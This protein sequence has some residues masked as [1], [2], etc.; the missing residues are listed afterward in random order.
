MLLD[1]GAEHVLA[2]EPSAAF[3]VLQRN[4]A[5]HGQRVTCVLARGDELAP[6]PPVDLV[7]A[8]GVLHH[9]PEPGPVAAAA[10]AALR[11]GGR[12]VVWLYGKEGNAVYLA[13]VT[14]LR[15]VTTRLAAAPTEILA[16]VLNV[17]FTGYMRLARRVPLPLRGYIT[18]VFG[19]FTP[20]RRVQVIYDQLKPAYARYYTRGEAE[21]LLRNAG[22]QDVHVHHRHGY[23]WTVIGTKPGA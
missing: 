19:H 14:P 16:R 2:L 7:F 9:I 12:V 20:E 23:S 1:A 22:F 18:H 15:W 4:L 8:I 6:E 17:C 13:L 10:Y 21:V 11:P 3:E 5:H